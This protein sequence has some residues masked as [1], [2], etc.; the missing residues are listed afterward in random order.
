MPVGM[1]GEGASGPEIHA[2]EDEGQYRQR[3]DEEHRGRTRTRPPALQKSFEMKPQTPVPSDRAVLIWCW[4]RFPWIDAAQLFMENDMARR[5]VGIALKTLL[6]TRGTAFTAAEQ[7]AGKL[8]G[9]LPA[10][11]QNLETQVARVMGHLSAKAIWSNMS[12]SRNSPTETGTL[13]YAVLMSDPARFV[14]IVAIDHCG[15]VPD[16]RP[17]LSPAAGNVSDQGDEGPFR[18]SAGTLAHARHPLHL[19]VVGRPH[20]RSW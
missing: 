14:P 6:R 18:R 16:L 1:L 11:I 10:A 3:L 20:P 4:R 9:L 12:T 5:G 17:Y 13:Y 7:A 19:R 2:P 15:R 8:E